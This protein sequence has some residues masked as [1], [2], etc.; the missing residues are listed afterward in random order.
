MIWYIQRT[1]EALQ[2]PIGVSGRVEVLPQ[3]G[4]DEASARVAVVYGLRAQMRVCRVHNSSIRRTAVCGFVTSGVAQRTGGAR[5]G[6][7]SERGSRGVVGGI[8]G[9]G[10][11]CGADMS[12]TG[13]AGIVEVIGD[14]LF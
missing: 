11:C 9:F 8:G 12:S 6:S 4:A 1:E 14:I 3:T 5:R 7:F 2:A 13:R 10:F